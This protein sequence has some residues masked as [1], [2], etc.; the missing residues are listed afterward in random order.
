MSDDHSNEINVAKYIIS[1][2]PI[3][4]LP[5]SLENLS[6]VVG[7][8]VMDQP[9]IKSA[10][11]SYTEDHLT[12]ISNNG[13]KVIISKLNK[14]ANNTYYDQSQGIKYTLN[15]ECKEIT[16][17][18]NCDDSSTLR[19]AID[20][21]LTQYKEK[22]YK[23]TITTSNVYYDESTGNIN[24]IISAHNINMKN[25]WSGE[26]LSTWE[27]SNGKLKG[28][29]KANTYYYEEGNI[30][31]N[32]KT[33]FNENVSTGSDESTAKDILKIIEKKENDVQMDLEKVYDNFSDHYIKP[34]RRKLPITGT[35]MNWNL[36][37]IQYGKK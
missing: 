30:Q 16:N 10:I 32:V 35:K 14:D 36:N 5:Q 2:V 13:Q 29:I 7:E 12:Q 28:T 9:E 27:Y 25:F 1:Q 24:I 33:E 15:E 6:I 18:E 34:L 37:Q 23:H 20:D 31:F 22:Y 11:H 19:K 26:W 8:E 17:V 4:H 21:A 3:G